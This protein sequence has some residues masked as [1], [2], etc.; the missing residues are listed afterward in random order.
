M[1]EEKLERRERLIPPAEP[2][3]STHV[4]QLVGRVGMPGRLPLSAF[5]EER[6]VIGKGTGQGGLGQVILLSAGV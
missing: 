3:E 4:A 6:F 2:H 1:I 5:L